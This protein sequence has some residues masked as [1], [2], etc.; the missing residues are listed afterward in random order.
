MENKQ[1]MELLLIEKNE[2]IIDFFKIL[3]KKFNL[4]IKYAKSL[5]EFVELTKSNDFQNVICG[6]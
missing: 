1:N 5:D 4:R 3:T 6:G 2:A